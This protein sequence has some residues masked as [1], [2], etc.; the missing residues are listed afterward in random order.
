MTPDASALLRWYDHHRRV[1][2]WRSLPGHRPD[3]YAVWLSEIMLQQ[4]T[5]KAVI[6]YY[7]RFLTHYPTVQDLAAAPLEDVLHLWAGLGYYARARN[8]HA[9]AKRVS[10]RGGFPDTVEELLTLP[11]IGAYTARAI[12]TIA[13]GRPVVP[14][15][16]NVERVTARLNAIE[17]P[18]PASRPLLA[19]QAALLNDDPVAQSRPSDFAQALFDLG[20][21]ICTPR[22]PACLTCPWQTSCI[23]H[24]RGIAAQLPAKQPKQARPTRYGA[25]FL[26]HDNDGQIL[27]RT[28]PPTGLLGS[29]DELPGTDWRS[30]P[31]TDEEALTHAPC[32]THWVRRGEIRHVFTHFTLYLTVYEACL[33]QGHNAGID[34][35][36]GTFRSAKRAALPGVMKKCLA[37]TKQ[38]PE[39]R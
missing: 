3:P 17:D 31:W 9:C 2:P 32:L 34:S 14:V 39:T 35:S 19:R 27:L 38:T 4:T 29:M 33:P 15:D 25:H 6:A 12:A 23:A 26:L 20:A 21:T 37:L 18:L 1:L 36:F 13:F 11:G 24:A 22:S 7:E 16:G 5:V 28:R 8:L 10:E 30:T